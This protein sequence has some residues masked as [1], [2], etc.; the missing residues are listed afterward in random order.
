MGLG[1]TLLQTSRYDDDHNDNNHNNNDGRADDHHNDNRAD[2]NN[3]HNKQHHLVQQFVDFIVF[4]Q[5][6]IVF[7][8][9]RTTVD[10]TFL[11][12]VTHIGHDPARRN[13]SSADTRYLRRSRYPERNTMSLLRRMNNDFSWPSLLPD[14]PFLD[15]D[16]GWVDLITETTIRVEEFQED[17]QMVVRAEVPGADPD[18]DIEITKTDSSLRISVQRHKEAKTETRHH[19]RSEFQYGAFVR[20]VSLPAGT[21]EQDIKADYKDG[22]LEVRIPMIAAKA[23]QERIPISHGK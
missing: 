19:Y 7:V 10:L 13:G 22:I 9:D 15:F 23:K 17:G 18:K 5:F 12:F 2:H 21:A 3:D 6:V 16:R 11:P 20:T 14:R 1:R 8:V 4:E